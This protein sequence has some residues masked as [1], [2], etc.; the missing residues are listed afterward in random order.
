MF[1][2]GKIRIKVNNA[3]D[4]PTN[5]HI[6]AY[7]EQ[8]SLLNSTEYKVFMLL[9]EGFL[10]RECSQRLNMKRGDIRKIVKNI[11]TKLNVR[12]TAELIVNYR[13]SEE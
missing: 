12:N 3:D 4:S 1:W 11:Y 5:G 6:G 2:L 8:L 10:E 9:R 7:Q 13:E